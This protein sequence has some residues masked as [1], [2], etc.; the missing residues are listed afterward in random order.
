MSVLERI[1]SIKDDGKH[2]VIT[3]CGVKV[4]IK[5]AVD[6]ALNA[7]RLSQL[8]IAVCFF[9]HLRTYKKCAPFLRRNLLDQ[10]DCDLFMHTWT[11]LDSNTKAWHNYYINGETNETDIRHAYSEFKGLV[12]EEQKP[13]DLG[14]IKTKPCSN[15]PT[16]ETSIFGIDAMFH[17]IRESNRLREEYAAQNNIRY[18]FVLCVRPDIWLKKPL[19]IANVLV[20][21]SKE[22]IAHGW[23]AVSSYFSPLISGF[24]SWC[25]CDVLFFGTPEV[26]DDIVK[27]TTHH[28]NRFKPDTLVLNGPEYEFIKLIKER[29]WTPYRIDMHRGNDWEIYRPNDTKLR[30]RW[31][32][33]RIRRNY[34]RLYLLPNYMRQLFRLYF[35]ILNWNF[36][37]CIGIPEN[38]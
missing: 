36:D 8:K 4:K 25:A 5:N 14:T 16:S 26:I 6:T 7:D 9:G 17:S 34:V 29:G 38:N 2:K 18:D 35:A 23:F 19:N 11:T 31:I 27:N 21:L 1:L 20:S 32:R 22:E 24:E 37:C 30:K 15:D 33:I 13:Q 3:I 28:A 10:C 12:I